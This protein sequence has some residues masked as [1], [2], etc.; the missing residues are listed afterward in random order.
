MAGGKAAVAPVIKGRGRAKGSW[1]KGSWSKPLTVGPYGSA[2]L[3]G[4]RTRGRRDRGPEPASLKP[5][6]RA[7][8][9]RLTPD[10]PARAAAEPRAISVLL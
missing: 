7:G 3:R 4:G 10:P 5:R 8:A 1:A 9:M 2:V 6:N